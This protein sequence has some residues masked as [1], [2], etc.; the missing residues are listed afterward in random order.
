MPFTPFHFGPGLLLKGVMPNQFSLSTFALA[1]VAMDIEPLYRML[2]GDAVLH[3]ATHS[4]LGAAGIAAATAMWGR[5]GIH[6]AWRVYERLGGSALAS[7]PISALQ[8]WLSALLGTFSHVLMDA[9]MH[10]DM[11]PFLPLTDANP[12]LHVSW[13]EDVYLGCVLAGMVG[14][15]LILIRA[16]FQPEHSPNR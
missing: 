16:A 15:L 12:W 9:L 6:M 8:A 10:A 5:R 2:A 7:A 11:R 14:M 1:N 4:L 3:G 13:T